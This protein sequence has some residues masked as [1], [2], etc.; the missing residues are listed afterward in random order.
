MPPWNKGLLA[1]TSESVAKQSKSLSES[2]AAGRIKKVYTEEGR[3]KLSATA[4]KTGLGGY[5]PHP[6]RGVFYSGVWLDSKWEE[7][8]AKSLDES[9]IRWERPRTGFV[10][11]DEGHRYYPDFYLP[12]FDIFLDPKNDYLQKK[13]QVKIEQAQIRNNIKVYVLNEQQ[14][15]W[16]NIAA[17][18]QLVE[19]HLGKVEATSS[20]L[21][22]STRI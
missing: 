17:I 10:W 6:N 7:R 14:L 9:G 22:S 1:T 16:K 8:V 21:V 20:N 4:K 11:D 3:A 18:A 19:R 15:D 5:R 13:D 12:D 2:F